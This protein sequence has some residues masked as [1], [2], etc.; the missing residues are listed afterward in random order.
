MIVELSSSELNF[1]SGGDSG[2]CKIVADLTGAALGGITGLAVSGMASPAVGVPAGVLMG[3]VASAS[4]EHACN[5]AMGT[6]GSGG[7]NNH[8]LKPTGGKNKVPA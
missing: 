8:N 4:A 5:S 1:V 2:G 6:G 7:A 3:A